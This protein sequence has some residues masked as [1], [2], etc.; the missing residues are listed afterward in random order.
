VIKKSVKTKNKKKAK[1]N[2]KTIVRKKIDTV[3]LL[4]LL[5]HLI[6]VVLLDQDLM[7]KEKRIKLKIKKI[8]RI[9]K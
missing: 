2:Q 4:I 6:L 7:R 1:R 5:I 9:K 3:A 8:K